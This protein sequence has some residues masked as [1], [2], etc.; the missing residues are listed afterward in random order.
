MR[1]DLV[2]HAA[3]AQALAGALMQRAFPD[4]HLLSETGVVVQPVE[5]DGAR[6]DCRLMKDKT[7]DGR[8]FFFKKNWQGRWAS[9]A[10]RVISEP[11]GAVSFSVSSYWR[12]WRW[13]VPYL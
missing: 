9:V 7:P 8:V 13:P 6:W 3:E 2:K 1:N 11:T 4:Y 5:Y 12:D 10:G